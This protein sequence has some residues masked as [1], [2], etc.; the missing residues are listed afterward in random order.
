MYQSVEYAIYGFILNYESAHCFVHPL[1]FGFFL[2]V[3]SKF[4]TGKFWWVKRKRYKFL[5]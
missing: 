1:P 2:S 4:R 5:F 3:E